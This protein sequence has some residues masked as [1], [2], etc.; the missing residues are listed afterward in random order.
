MMCLVA[1]LQVES[2]LSE[3]AARL[4]ELQGAE[5][6][7]LPAWLSRKMDS[8]FKYASDTWQQVHESEYAAQV[9]TAVKPHWEW[10]KEAAAPAQV[11]CA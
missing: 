7:Y 1:L 11:S 5:D 10:L 4:A 2:Q 6:A 9:T 3:H 8:S